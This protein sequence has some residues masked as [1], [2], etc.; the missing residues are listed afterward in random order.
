[1]GGE[2]RNMGMSRVPRCPESLLLYV[3]SPYTSPVP[4]YYCMP[5]VPIYI[6][7]VPTYYCM[8]PV[9]IYMPYVPSPY[10]YNMSPVPI[11]ICLY[12]YM[13]LW[14]SVPACQRASCGLTA[15]SCPYCTPRSFGG[16]MFKTCKKS[17]FTVSC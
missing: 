4:T 2:T 15:V 13:S 3:P 5:P 8:P 12:A 16:S 6:S 7:P 14:T 11:T 9:P 10:Y 17:T 1:M